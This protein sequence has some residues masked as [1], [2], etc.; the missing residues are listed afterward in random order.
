MG[1]YEAKPA[2]RLNRDPQTRD[3]KGEFGKNVFPP[4]TARD[5]EVI[6]SFGDYRD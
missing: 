4:R 2:G 5:W 3:A 6:R 1:A